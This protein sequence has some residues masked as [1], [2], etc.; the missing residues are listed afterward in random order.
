[1]KY[2]NI[3]KRN[4]QTNPAKKKKK[5]NSPKNKTKQKKKKPERKKDFV[6]EVNLF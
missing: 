5:K 3:Q 4:K 2:L 6:Y 1:M